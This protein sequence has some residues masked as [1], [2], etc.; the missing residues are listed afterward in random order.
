MIKAL[1]TALAM[2]ASF[3]LSGCV[4]LTSEQGGVFLAPGM[5]VSLPKARYEGSFEALQLLEIEYQDAGTLR[6]ESVMVSTSLGKDFIALTALSPLG[7][8]LFEISSDS[9]GKITAQSHV[10]AAG[11]P[12]PRQVL[13]DMMLSFYDRNYLEGSLGASVKIT[14]TDTKRTVADGGKLIY[15]IEYLEDQ[16]IRIPRVIRH[17]IFGYTI[18]IGKLS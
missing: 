2:L 9:E 8:R 3:A 4:S 15:E 5:E 14:D 11:L 10:S 1:I 6:H 17:L 13:L 16:G 18:S 12:D 7:M